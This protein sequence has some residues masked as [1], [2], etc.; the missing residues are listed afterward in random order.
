VWSSRSYEAQAALDIYSRMTLNFS[1]LYLSRARLTS[2]HHYE[3]FTVVVG[4][5]Y[6]VFLMH[7]L[8]PNPPPFNI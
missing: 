7:A 3:Q 5:E 2:M 4:I 1:G 6:R 8:Y